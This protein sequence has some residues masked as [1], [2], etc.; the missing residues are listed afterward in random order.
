MK[1]LLDKHPA[2]VLEQKQATATR[3]TRLGE[4]KP[5]ETKDPFFLELWELRNLGHAIYD[6]EQCEVTGD[7]TTCK[8]CELLS[9]NIG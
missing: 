3:P 4:R 6:G 9:A 7:W 8:E 5:M 1:T 2:Y